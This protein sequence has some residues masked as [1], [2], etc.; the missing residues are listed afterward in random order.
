[1]N[2]AANSA[3]AA[4]SSMLATSERWTTVVRVTSPALKRLNIFTALS[5]TLIVS[6]VSFLGLRIACIKTLAS[7]NLNQEPSSLALNSRLSLW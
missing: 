3:P 1:M 2:L 4:S 5:L 7:I 6:P